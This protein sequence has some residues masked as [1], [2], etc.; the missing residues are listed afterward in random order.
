MRTRRHRVDVPLAKHDVV[1]PADFD[2]V[3]ILGIEQDVIAG[4]C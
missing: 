2:L 1:H 4:L 3:A